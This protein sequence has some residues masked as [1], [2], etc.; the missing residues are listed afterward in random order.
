MARRVVTGG[1]GFLGSHLVDLLLARGD[2]V[3]VIDNL[4]TGTRENLAHLDT[5]HRLTVIEHDVTTSITVDGPVDSILHL[6]SPAS[7]VDYLRL[8]IETLRAGSDGTLNGLTLAREKN[9]TFML[10][11]T[12]EIYG[13]PQVHPQREDYWGHVNPNGPRSVYDEAKRFAEAATM[14]YQ[15]EH[16][17]ST[18]IARIFN[19]YGPRMKPNDGRVVS[20]FIMQALRNEP[21]TIYGDGSQTRSFCFVGDEARGLLALHDSD[22]DEPTNIGNPAEFTIAELAE[23]VL[24]ITGS[25]STIEYR[26]LPTDDPA[27]RKPDIGRAR[28]LLG[29]EPTMDL[30][31]GLALTIA[32]FR[33]ILT[34]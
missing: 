5:S 31:E 14:A 20:N 34:R 4:V 8:P 33:A 7:P 13:D 30:R 12:S 32:Y 6:A 24:E 11:S 21:L 1:A 10:A 28:D 23:L 2:E 29:W 9:A 16:G 18:K 3:I 19:T 25:E 15:R 22:V 27:K 26:A 17:V